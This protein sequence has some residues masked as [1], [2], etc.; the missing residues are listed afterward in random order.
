MYKGLKKKNEKII[1]IGAG[2]HAKVIIDILMTS[3]DHQI[4]GLSTPHIGERILCGIPVI[5]DDSRFETIYKEGVK[6]VFVAIG[7]NTKRGQ[8]SDYVKNMVLPSRM[9]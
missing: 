4:A 7:D 8:I 5:G 3:S 9:R 6:S 1:I 2:G